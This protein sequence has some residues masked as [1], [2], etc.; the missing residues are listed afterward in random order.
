MS[1]EER[2]PVTGHRSPSLQRCGRAGSMAEDP[3]VLKAACLPELQPLC[4]A[5]QLLGSSTCTH[6]V[7]YTL[8]HQISGGHLAFPVGRQVQGW[9]MPLVPPQQLPE[10][11]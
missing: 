8:C 7:K 2:W 10:G 6:L 3:A 5:S 11:W 1:R 9:I 4:S